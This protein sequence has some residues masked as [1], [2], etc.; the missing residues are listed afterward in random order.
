MKESVLRIVH[1]LYVHG[2]AIARECVSAAKL[3][4]RSK[5]VSLV[6]PSRSVVWG[7]QPLAIYS[8]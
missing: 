5:M 1:K 8:T 2:P 7:F 4:L 6:A 3:G